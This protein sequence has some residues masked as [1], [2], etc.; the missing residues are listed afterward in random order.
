[1][2]E[3]ERERERAC[4]R[5]NGAKVDT[6][7]TAGELWW[8][9]TDENMLGQTAVIWLIKHVS[10]N[11]T[12]RPSNQSFR[13]GLVHNSKCDREDK[14]RGHTRSLGHTKLI[15]LR[16]GDINRMWQNIYTEY[17]IRLAY[18]DRVEREK[19]H[20]QRGLIY[21]HRQW[22]TIEVTGK[23][24]KKKNILGQCP[25]SNWVHQRNIF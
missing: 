15:L 11:T 25:R 13:V 21:N 6:L 8:N 9:E 5:G 16:V 20:D 17:I 2:E 1:M 7:T 22:D 24:K 23:K 14:T 10:R 4:Q 18:R 12:I 3:R 19:E